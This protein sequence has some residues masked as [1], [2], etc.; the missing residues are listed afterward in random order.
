VTVTGHQAIVLRRSGRA[1]E[2]EETLT[3]GPN[4]RRRAGRTLFQPA[5][6]SPRRHPAVFQREG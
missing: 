2:D 6:R 5:T 1:S 4:D 3:H